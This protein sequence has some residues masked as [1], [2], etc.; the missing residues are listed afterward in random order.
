MWPSA[1]P[2]ITRGP[3]GLIGVTGNATDCYL[4]SR[5]W[6]NGG[7]VSQRPE[8]LM[9]GEHGI[10]A[11]VLQDDGS[12]WFMDERLEPYPTPEPAV[13]GEGSASNFCEGAM[14]AGLSAEEAVRLAVKH[15]VH[16]GGDVQVE[17]LRE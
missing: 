6:A 2:K 14:H 5:W 1:F 8:K 7:Y 3:N 17:R 12:V 13:T 16:V 9:Q 15:C 10:G 11:I 4:V